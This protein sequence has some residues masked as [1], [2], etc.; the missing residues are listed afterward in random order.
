MKKYLAVI[1]A[2]VVVLSAALYFYSR[3]AKREKVPVAG[4]SIPSAAESGGAAAPGA[5]AGEVLETMASGGY[6]YVHVKTREGTVWAAGPETPVK[7]GDA[8]S[9]PGGMRMEKFRSETLN[10]DFDA[11]YFVSEIRVGSAGASPTPST[12][13]Q[14]HPPVGSGGASGVPQGIDLSGIEV[15]DGGKNIVALYADKKSL[16]G[17]EVIV[18]GKVVKFTQGVMGKNWIHLRD[19][20][21]E[22]GTNDLTVT[23]DATVAVGDLV[24]ARGTV[25]LDKDFGF[26]YSYVILVEDAKVTKE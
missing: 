24:T 17:K 10:R 18:R 9:M 13:P 3:S 19:G 1:I 4:H 25:V 20:T 22:E 7:V 5:L 21:G 11:V 8:V 23:T 26:G 2:V 15:P 14:G 6:T 12:V 16:E